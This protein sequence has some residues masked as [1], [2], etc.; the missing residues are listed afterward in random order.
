MRPFALLAALLMCVSASLAAQ[1]PPRVKIVD[2]A[3]VPV[4]FAVV[5]LSGGASRF[6]NSEGGLG[7]SGDARDSIRITARRMGYRAFAGWV[8]EDATRTFVVVLDRIAATLDTIQVSGLSDTP[9]MRTGFYDRALRV[10]NGAILGEFLG[11]EDLEERNASRTSQLLSGRRYARVSQ[12]NSGG[13]PRPVILGRGG[14]G[15]TVLIDGQRMTS[16]LQDAIAEEVPTSINGGTRR[17]AGVKL[18]IDELVDGRSVMAIEIYP[19]T[20]N[21]PAELQTLGGRGSCGIVAVWT[22]PRKE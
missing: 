11:P 10:R 8:H 18:D 2:E 21:A 22:G 3:G 13:R 9:L 6:A 15:M 16:T 20:A 7:L 14:C 5:V 12:Y 4:P 1:S 17:T 19:S